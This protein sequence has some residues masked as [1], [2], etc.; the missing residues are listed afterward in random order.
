MTS[1]HVSSQSSDDNIQMPN[2]IRDAITC[3]SRLP[4]ATPEPH[5]CSVDLQLYTSPLR[6]SW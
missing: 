1:L 4:T 5:G 3:S 2:A 6:Y